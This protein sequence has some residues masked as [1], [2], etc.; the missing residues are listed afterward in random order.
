[1]V[2]LAIKTEGRGEPPTEGIIA[3]T[4]E[5]VNLILEIYF[6]GYEDGLR[7]EER[8]DLV[9]DIINE[10]IKNGDALPKRDEKTQRFIYVGPRK[11]L[12]YYYHRNT[13][14]RNKRVFI[15]HFQDE[16]GKPLN[17]QTFRNDC[18]KK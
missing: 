1:M 14:C 3:S 10:A 8:E 16:F 9:P 4:D 6:A 7:H 18:A 5:L 17:Y 13:T 11:V 2:K 12:A 15:K